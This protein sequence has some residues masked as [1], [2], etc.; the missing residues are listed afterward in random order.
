MQQHL[1][2]KVDTI[3]LLGLQ[4]LAQERYVSS[5]PQH[6]LQKPDI[7]PPLGLQLLAQLYVSSQLMKLQIYASSKGLRLDLRPPLLPP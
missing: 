7:I 4:L 6:L 1:L 2:Q 5:Q 3:P